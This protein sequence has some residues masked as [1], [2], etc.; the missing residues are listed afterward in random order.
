[1]GTRFTIIKTALWEVPRNEIIA[2]ETPEIAAENRKLQIPGYCV[3][4]D[5]PKLGKV[6][7][8]TGIA[9]DKDI[10]WREEQKALYNFQE[11][12]Y[13]D[14]K[15]A[16]LGLTVNDIDL[17]VISHLHY[18]HGGN[19]KMFQNTKAGQ[20]GIILSEP[21]A[22][23][24]FVKV[25]LDDTGFSYGYV[26][27]E[28]MNLRGIKYNLLTEDTWL[29]DDLFL[30]IQA[31]HTPGVLGM[32]V[33]TENEGNYIFTSDAVYSKLNYGPP[34]VLPGICS[35]PV[36]YKAN[37][38]R[39]HKLSEEHNAELFVGHDTGDFN[40]WKLSPQWYG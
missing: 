39:L 15:L 23:Q 32:L 20:N 30:F 31:G 6:L 12:Y 22:Q 4:I 18:D 11:F 25:N 5:H 9:F 28:F 8:D 19:I 13:L 37:I 7:Y 24:A 14:E 17:I 34:I 3:L 38:E 2:P 21:E 16:E 33:K 35:D 26:K 10:S 29:A 36:S 27:N 40:T 1:M